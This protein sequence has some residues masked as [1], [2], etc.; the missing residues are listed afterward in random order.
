MLLLG[1]TQQPLDEL[2]AEITTGGGEAHALTADLTEAGAG[3]RI[4]QR[5]SEL[6]AY[7]DVLVNSA[8]FGV[9]GP[10]ATTDREQH[11]GFWT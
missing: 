6:G 3:P 10:A 5:L 4:E 1:F 8:G 2:A 9:F 11:L 7:C